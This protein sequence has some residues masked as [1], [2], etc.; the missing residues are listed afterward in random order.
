MF[1][2][3]NEDSFFA[4][5]DLVEDNIERFDPKDDWFPEVKDLEMYSVGKDPICYPMLVF[6]AANP[7]KNKFKD[8]ETNEKYKNTV[9]KAKE[10]L[11]QVSEHLA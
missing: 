10:L 8:E 6:F 2:I 4:D 3:K 9:L 1:D 11:L 5:C 7:Y